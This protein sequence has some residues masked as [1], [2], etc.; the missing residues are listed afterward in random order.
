MRRS[1]YLLVL[2]TTLTAVAA[3]AAEPMLVRATV[4]TRLPRQIAGVDAPLA[5]EP[6]TLLTPPEGGWPASYDAIKTSLSKRAKNRNKVLIS[7]LFEPKPLSSSTST[8]FFIPELQRAFEV[9]PNGDKID[10][11]LPKAK[12]PISVPA[13]AG[14][15]NMFGAEDEMVY[16]GVMLVP[17]SKVVDDTMVIMNGDK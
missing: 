7:Q 10:V 6:T 13:V 11:L 3:S 9:K 12:E 4:Y 15:T 14:V 5:L 1:I 8:A 17:A 2:L 16:I